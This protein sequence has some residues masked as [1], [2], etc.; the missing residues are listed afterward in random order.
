[1]CVVLIVYFCITRGV[2]LVSLFSR[3][4][5]VFL[6]YTSTTTDLLNLVLSALR[7]LTDLNAT[8]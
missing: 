7:D 1:M 3:S 5:L 8:R 6:P 2:A 4:Y